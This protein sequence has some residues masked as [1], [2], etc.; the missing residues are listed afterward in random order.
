MA[1]MVVFF[2]NYNTTYIDNTTTKNSFF[3][4]YV[5]INKSINKAAWE[6]VECAWAGAQNKPALSLSDGQS[7]ELSAVAA[8]QPQSVRAEKGNVRGG[9]NLR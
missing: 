9:K 4:R 2:W 5:I 7:C 8:H 3:S 6:G 1:L